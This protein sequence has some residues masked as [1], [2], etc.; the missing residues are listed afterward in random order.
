MTARAIRQCLG[1]A[2]ALVAAGLVAAWATAA[3]AAEGPLNDDPLTS[4]RTEWFREAKFGMFIHWGLYA[5]PAGVYDGK[6]IG[7]IGEWIM[8]NAKIPIPEY[9]KFAKEFNPVKFDAKEWVRI[10]KDAGMKYMVITSKHHDGFCMWPTKLTP[11][12][13]HDAT[14]FTRDPIKELADACKAAGLKFC[15]YHSIMDWHHPDA[16][17]AAFP[18]YHEHLKGQLRE[19]VSN[20]G[21]LGILW[22]DG[23]WIGEWDDAKGK[24]L[25]AYVRGLQNDIIINN[26]V[27]KRAATD[28]DYETPEQSIPAG[29]IQGRLWETCMTLNDTW[30]FKKNDQNWKPAADLVRKLVDIA[31]KGGNFLLNVGP[32]AEGV[33]PQPSV[34]RL[35]ET[36][37]WL[38]RN[39]QAVYGTTQS[40]WKKHPFDGRC[41]VKGNTLYVSVFSWP[42]GGVRLAGLLGEVVGVAA[43]DPGVGQ[44][45]H[46]VETVEGES[47]L[48]QH[49]ADVPGGLIEHATETAPPTRTLT[50]R[51]PE[52]PDPIA[53]VVVV[54][55]K[56]APAVDP[57]AA[58]PPVRQADDGSVTLKAADAT[59]HG[60]TAQYESGGGKDNIG[61]WTN[62][63]D[64]VSWNVKVTRPGT[65]TV[66]ITYA[67]EPGSAG[68]EYAV[69]VGDEQVAGKTANTGSWTEFKTE[70]LGT[71][72]IPAAG[73]VS[74]AVKPKTKPGV[75]VMNLKAIALKM[76]KE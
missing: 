50:I 4:S 27:G 35:R 60:D 14:P 56:E 59:I 1:S 23:E 72:K 51:P 13:I 66:E 32:T 33:I 64:W 38:K 41:T 76:S 75:G 62:P 26:R 74:V 31:S 22:F 2:A 55:F 19:L 70:T 3:V 65:F 10:A 68:S 18:K 71:L 29:A 24:D 67:S 37:Q 40:P 52:R 54:R 69:T 16:R 7:G 6:E 48:V 39:G 15:F 57:L 34:D 49:P 43:L 61:F 30:G 36:G 17:G 8:D 11:Y 42:E 25:Y 12:N 53:T 21:P 47:V 44:T 63:Q 28:G 45:E 5:V 9:E 20:Y 46:K 58:T 73:T